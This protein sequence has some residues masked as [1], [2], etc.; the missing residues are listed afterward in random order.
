MDL[1]IDWQLLGFKWQMF[2]H[3]ERFQKVEKFEFEE[4]PSMTICMLMS[5]H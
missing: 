2:Q 3:V 1:Q 4:S 5:H